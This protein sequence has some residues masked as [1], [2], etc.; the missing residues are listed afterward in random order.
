MAEVKQ[1]TEHISMKEKKTQNEESLCFFEADEENKKTT[2]KVAHREDID[3]YEEKC[4]A[5]GKS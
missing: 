2:P 5:K 3:K 1:H 4:K